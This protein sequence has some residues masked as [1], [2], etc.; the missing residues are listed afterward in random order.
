LALYGKLHRRNDA[1]GALLF[2]GLHAPEVV[3]IVPRPLIPPEESDEPLDVIPVMS[4]W[5][6]GTLLGIVVG[7][8]AVFGIALWLDP[9]DRATTRLRPEFVGAFATAPDAAFPGPVPWAA[10]ALRTEEAPAS[11]VARRIDTPRHLR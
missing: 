2:L 9:Y 10:L 5:V 6:R 1:I 7:L 11:P 8:V 3:A 4:H